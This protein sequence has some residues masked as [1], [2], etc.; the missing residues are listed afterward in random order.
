MTVTDGAAMEYIDLRSLGDTGSQPLVTVVIPTY[1]DVKHLPA[2]IRSAQLQTLLRVEIIVSDDASTDDTASVVASIQESDTR[3]KYV[4]LS[5]NTGGAGAPRNEAIRAALGQYVMFLDSDDQLDRHACKNLY[6]RAQQTGAN[7]V[8]GVTQR[9]QVETGNAHK[10]YPHLYQ[11]PLYLDGID[12]YPEFTHDTLV[13]NKLFDRSFLLDAK[14]EFPEDMHYEDVVFAAQAYACAQGIATIYET[15]YWWNVYPEDVRKSITN[16]RDLSRNLSDR[17]RAIDAVRL[18]FR[19]SSRQVQDEVEEKV[20]LHHLRLYVDDLAELPSHEAMLLLDTVRAELM[21]I[22]PQVFSRVGPGL[23]MMYASV[24]AE[25]LDAVEVTVRALRQ[26]AFPGVVIGEG[27]HRT[28]APSGPGTELDLP[29]D[30]QWITS[31]ANEP[32]LDRPHSQVDYVHTVT[33]WKQVGVA[34]YQMAAELVD[35]LGKILP[36]RDS[37]VLRYRGFLGDILERYPLTLT[38]TSSVFTWQ[39]VVDSPRRLRFAETDGRTFDIEITLR[40]GAS[41]I[42]PVVFDLAEEPELIRD[43]SRVGKLFGDFWKFTSGRRG[44][45]ELQIETVGAVGRAVRS[46][47]K[48]TVAIKQTL[49]TVVDWCTAVGGP[50]SWF[51]QSVVYASMRRLPLDRGLAFFESNLGL[52]AQDSPFAVYSRLRREFPEIRTVWS[53]DERALAHPRDEIQKTVKRKS[54]AYYFMLARSRYITDNQSLAANFVKRPGQTYLQ[55]WHGI[56]LKKMGIDQPGFSSRGARSRLLET[57]GKWDLL[58]SPCP[59]FEDTFV[60]AFGYE[61]R[62]VRQGTPRNDELIRPERELPDIR[63][64][65]DIGPD[66]RIVLYAPTFRNELQNRSVAAKLMIDIDEWLEA[67]DESTVLL[68]RAHYLNR[69]V[70]PRQALGRVVDVSQYADVA[71]LYR[72]ADVLITDYSSVMFDYAHLRRPIVIFAPDYDHYVKRSRGVYFDLRDE[73]PGDFVETT[74]ALVH[75]VQRSLESGVVGRAHED[76]VASYCGQ[77]DG[78]ASLRSVH[79]LLE[80]KK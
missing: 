23:R 10:W 53:L 22:P 56:P 27:A 37:V 65:L 6:L 11:V 60:R 36:E 26:G 8:G 13:T 15:V 54:Y 76:F 72:L 20:L 48:V 64:H 3:V 7:I 46:A 77:E 66:K 9:L 45:P 73:A 71:D 39:T 57:S 44:I 24:I 21:D 12:D 49:A 33:E 70:V 63:D 68:V 42:R 17:L 40:S 41:N 52:E 78:Y 51:G 58:T 19:D 5:E 31:L 61:G 2:A 28:W 35:P 30:W 1:N 55:T 80:E 62:L 74:E 67:F 79:A 4:R 50:E 43:M 29:A 25:R 75:S 34:S 38:G 47:S 59:Y 32:Q 18:A 14:L 69:F 16:Q